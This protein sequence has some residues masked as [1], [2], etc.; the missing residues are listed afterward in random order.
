M[1][2]PVGL[3]VYRVKGEM[4]RTNVQGRREVAKVIR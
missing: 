4:L 1:S 2:L 3:A